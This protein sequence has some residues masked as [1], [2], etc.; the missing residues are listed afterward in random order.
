MHLSG[1]VASAK[2]RTR[3]AYEGTQ[4]AIIRL[5]VESEAKLIIANKEKIG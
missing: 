5:P 4:T 1:M 2:E 3:M